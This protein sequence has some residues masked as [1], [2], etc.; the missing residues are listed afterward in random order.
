MILCAGAGNEHRARVR[1]APFRLPR[2]RTRLPGARLDARAALQAARAELRD[3]A[4]MALHHCLPVEP[5]SGAVCGGWWPRCPPLPTHEH[6]IVFG[7][8]DPVA[9]CRDVGSIGEI[10]GDEAEGSPASMPPTSGAGAG[11]GDR[12]A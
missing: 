12:R 5:N 11:V 8:N 1:V 10:A 4:D 7:R 9:K 6:G 3:V 2:Q